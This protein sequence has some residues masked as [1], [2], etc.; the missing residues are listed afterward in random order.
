MKLE[1]I[2]LT[3]RAAFELRRMV[4]KGELA[5]GERLTEQDL[6]DR[7]Q[8]GRGTI[9]AAL[10]ALET[11]TL[12]TRRPYAGWAVADIDARTLQ[13]TYQVRSAL[14]ELAARLVAEAHSTEAERRL[15]ELS[16]DLAR[17]EVSST[18]EDRVRA[19][20]AFHDGIVRQSGNALLIGQY[21]SIIGRV[22]WLYRWSEK[23][24]PQRINLVEWHRP[25]LD[26][27]LSGDGDGAARTMRNHTNS[28]LRDDVF[29]LQ[30]QQVE[31]T[32]V[33]E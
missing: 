17:A 9:R 33:S 10:A 7:M 12:I 20:L 26:A 30:N 18:T 21:K 4:V 24:W 1:K 2:S 15:G 25:I 22:E 16:E 13:E 14:E 23:N 32:G 8:V 5:P 11:E 28:S 31:T 3:D 27:I 29:D 6:A 19:D